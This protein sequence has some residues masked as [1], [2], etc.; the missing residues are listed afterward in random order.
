MFQ[1]VDEASIRHWY[2]YLSSQSRAP[3][4]VTTTTPSQGK[5]KYIK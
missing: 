3:Q 4:L 5:L 1:A 2:K